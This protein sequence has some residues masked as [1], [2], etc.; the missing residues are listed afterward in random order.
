MGMKIMRG[1]SWTRG[2]DDLDCG[3][4]DFREGGKEKLEEKNETKSIS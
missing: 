3:G 1:E 4:V 2:V